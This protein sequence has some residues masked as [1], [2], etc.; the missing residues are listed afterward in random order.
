MSVGSSEEVIN[1]PKEDLSEK[2]K[3]RVKLVTLQRFEQQ[4]NSVSH[5]WNNNNQSYSPNIREGVDLP[6]SS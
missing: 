6:Y 2:V 5:Q 1:R 4:R 3:N